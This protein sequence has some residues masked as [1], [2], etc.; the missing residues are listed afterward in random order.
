MNLYEWDTRAK[1]LL[2]DVRDAE[3]RD[4]EYELSGAAS[5]DADYEHNVAVRKQRMRFA[6]WFTREDVV[7]IDSK[8]STLNEQIFYLSEK[9][10]VFGW[11]QTLIGF[12]ILVVLCDIQ[13]SI[14]E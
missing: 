11:I 5:F 7:L 4:I 8:L 12:S 6:P 9:K 14:F 3:K 2:D 1:R 10:S 13:Y